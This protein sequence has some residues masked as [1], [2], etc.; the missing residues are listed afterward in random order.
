MGPAVDP[1][2]QATVR[3]RLIRHRHLIT[4]MW[5]ER[6]QDQVLVLVLHVEAMAPPWSAIRSEVHLTRRSLIERLEPNSKGIYASLDHAEASGQAPV[7]IRLS[8]GREQRSI[9]IG[10]SWE[11]VSGSFP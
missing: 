11:D 5:A 6:R 7:V 1:L 4:Q 3:Q 9:G 10:V 2:F 8:D